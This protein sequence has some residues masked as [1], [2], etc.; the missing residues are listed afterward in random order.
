MSDG[1]KRL[2]CS[3]LDITSVF[4]KRN[5]RPRSKLKDLSSE[6]L[7]IGSG[8]YVRSLYRD[9]VPLH[10]NKLHRLVIDSDD[11]LDEKDPGVFQSNL[12]DGEID[13]HER[14]Q[15]L[16]FCVNFMLS[17]TNNETRRQVS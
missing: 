5:T 8:W 10:V 13:Y 17:R 15:A 14:R 3:I 1:K 11:K 4:D 9:S 16:L 6:K 7:E 2:G 12:I